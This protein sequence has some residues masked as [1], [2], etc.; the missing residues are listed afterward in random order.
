[1]FE[2]EGRVLVSGCLAGV[3]CNYKG[4]AKPNS[5]VL[6]LV[7]QGR[8]VVVCPEQLGGFTNSQG[9]GRK[10]GK[11]GCARSPSCGSGQI[12]DGTFTG[13]LIQG[14]GVLAEKLKKAGILIVSS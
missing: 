9:S 5:M 3:R 13:K 12:Y 11:D 10:N 1:M 4:E 6:E 8:A 2:G 7:R 14:D